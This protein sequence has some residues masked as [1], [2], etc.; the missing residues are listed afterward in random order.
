MD[1][2]SLVI[3]YL[4]MY[5]IPLWFKPLTCTCLEAL[6]SILRNFGASF[7]PCNTSALLGLYFIGSTHFKCAMLLCL[8]MALHSIMMKWCSQS[9]IRFGNLW[10]GRGG[11]LLMQSPVQKPRPG[12]PSNAA[13][14]VDVQGWPKT[15]N[16]YALGWDS[17]DPIL[18]QR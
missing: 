14:W 8:L 4:G 9:C 1:A 3:D 10:G 11:W 6:R 18:L 13:C 5:G 12:C 17:M 16:S 7:R 2:R 15:L